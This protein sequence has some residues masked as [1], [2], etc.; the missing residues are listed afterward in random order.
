[1]IRL[2]VKVHNRQYDDLRSQRRI[3]ETKG[4]SPHATAPRA[5]AE[6]LPS[7]RVLL[8]AAKTVANLQG[9]L[10]A[11]SRQQSIVVSYRLV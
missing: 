8:N 10:R 7:F 5:L 9:E 4:K 11:K 6:E 1:M 3:Y 2:S